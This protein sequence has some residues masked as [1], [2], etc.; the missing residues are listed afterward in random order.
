MFSNILGSID[1]VATYPLV[2]LFVFIPFF[3]AVTA[4]V[5]S[6]D[7]KF[8]NDMSALPLQDSTDPNEE[9]NPLL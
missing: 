5:I 1:G 9:G 6:L 7:K 3:L 4:W 8:L 2:S